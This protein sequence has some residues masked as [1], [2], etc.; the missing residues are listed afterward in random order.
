MMQNKPIRTLIA[1]D[2]AFVREILK[3]T[4]N[5]DSDIVIVGE[6]GDG[7]EVLDLVRET[8]PDVL[9]LDIVLPGKDGL[10]ILRELMKENPIPVIVFSSLTKENAEVTLEALN[11]GAFDF[12]LKSDVLPAS[13]CLSEVRWKFIR[14]IKLA[15][16]IGPMK[17]LMRDLETKK[18]EESPRIFKSAD[19]AVVI[20]ASTG[21]PSIVK[22]I[23]SELPANIPAAVLVVQH[24]PPIF[25]KIF[26]ERLNNETPLKVKEAEDGDELLTGTVYVSPGDYHMEI[27]NCA[28][29]FF[30]QLTR[31]PR[32]H[33][34][35]PS[36]KSVAQ[37]F[38]SKSIAVV[39]TGIG[40][41]GAKGSLEIKRTGGFVIVQNEKTSLIYG[42]P[43]A[44][45]DSG[46]TDVVMD[47]REIPRNII[48]ILKVMEMRRGKRV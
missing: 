4:L 36:L 47:Y 9:L 41:D 48:R 14:K 21:G 5:Q 40:Y 2:S 24:M 39:L 37:F 19:T 28:N 1:D 29:S 33:G 7:M 26:A 25:T 31:G 16:I 6:T 38:G 23:L 27:R 3:K 44:V 34:V 15:A 32:V 35:R 43:K 10:T 12:I 42:M 22:Y 13:R 17:L 11:R 45:V 30:I 20:G 8:K 18:L 46:A